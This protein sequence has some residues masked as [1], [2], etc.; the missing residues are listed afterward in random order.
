[1]EAKAPVVLT[2]KVAKV[3]AH[4]Q[5]KSMKRR[6]NFNEVWVSVYL[7]LSFRGVYNFQWAIYNFLSYG[8]V[9]RN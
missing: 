3:E 7:N 9:T 8:Q 4:M 1:M 5:A 2:N 6:C